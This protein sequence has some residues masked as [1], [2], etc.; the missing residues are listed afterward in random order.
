[1]L[2]FAADGLGLGKAGGGSVGAGARKRATSS[3]VGSG[4]ATPKGNAA[5]P[6]AGKGGSVELVEWLVECIEDERNSRKAAFDVNTV[7]SLAS[8]FLRCIEN[9]D[10]KCRKA[11]VE[12]LTSVLT[13]G[14]INGGFKV[15]AAF[16]LCYNLPQ[17]NA[18]VHAGIVKTVNSR[19][20]VRKNEGIEKEAEQFA[21][22]LRQKAEGEFAAVKRRVEVEVEEV[23]SVAVVPTDSPRFN[24]LNR[25]WGEVQ[26][27]L[28]KIPIRR[29]DV[30]WTLS[31]SRKGIY[32]LE[33]LKVEAS[34]LGM[35]RG[36]LSRCVLPY[37]ED[38][39]TLD[40]AN[41]SASANPEDMEKIAD[42]DE[43]TIVGMREGAIAL[44]GLVRVKIA[45]DSDIE[46]ASV[47]LDDVKTFFEMLVDESEK[48]GAEAFELL[49]SLK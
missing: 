4:N 25:R 47:A 45:D 22:A 7:T 10:V 41:V 16:D 49:R 1:V 44:R 11:A 28:R 36:A 27:L 35:L 29:E 2:G 6:A 30:A 8:L 23:E 20:V 15:D 39:S 18:K 43:S 34:R 21:G 19:V 26:Y 3:A 14:I 40:Q 24:E 12:G 13:I 42:L 32:F 31:E 48:R 46:L 33:S 5:A 37:N 9:R 17:T 38:T